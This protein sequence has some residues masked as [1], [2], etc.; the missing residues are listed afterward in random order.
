[1]NNKVLVTMTLQLEMATYN[2]D[3]D[4]FLDECR[5]HGVIVN[6]S[7]EDLQDDPTRPL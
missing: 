3:A 5:A 2:Q 1:M 7:I 6:Y 4:M